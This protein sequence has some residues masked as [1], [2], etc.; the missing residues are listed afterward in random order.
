MNPFYLWSRRYLLQR[1]PVQVSID[2]LMTFLHGKGVRCH[3]MAADDSFEAALDILGHIAGTG[4]ANNTLDA[5]VNALVCAFEC[6]TL[7]L[8]G[9]YDL[10]R[11]PV[12]KMLSDAT[13]LADAEVQGKFA[14]ADEKTRAAF[15]ILGYIL[16][17]TDDFSAST[18]AAGLLIIQLEALGLFPQSITSQDRHE[19]TLSYFDETDTEIV[20]GRGS[21]SNTAP[22]MRSLALAVLMAAQAG[23]IWRPAVQTPHVAPNPTVHAPAGLAAWALSQALATGGYAL[24]TPEESAVARR[25]LAAGLRALLEQSGQLGQEEARRMIQDLDAFAVQVLSPEIIEQYQQHRQDRRQ[26]LL[27]LTHQT[28][29]DAIKRGWIVLPKNLQLVD[30]LS[31]ARAWQY[32]CARTGHPFI[33]VC[34]QETQ[35]QVTV[36]PSPKPFEPPVLPAAQKGKL[37]TLYQEMGWGM[38]EDGLTAHGP[39]PD[40]TPVNLGHAIAQALDLN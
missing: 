32:R 7:L 29:Q 28:F 9:I 19:T 14:W 18:D 40:M 27:D 22:P 21:C 6:G 26:A 3:I 5:L 33:A 16:N 13:L 34:E 8:E 39:L 15:N 38:S 11:T 20:V 2:A 37:T 24:L 10:G 25:T 30:K 23:H 17:I 1:L 36:M 4:I 35:Y 12:Q 31:L